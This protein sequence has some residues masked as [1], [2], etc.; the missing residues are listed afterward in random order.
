MDDFFFLADPRTAVA[1]VP[2]FREAIVAMM[3]SRPGGRAAIKCLG[4]GSAKDRKVMLRSVKDN[5]AEAACH[6][7]GHLVLVKALDVVDDT[8]LLRK[9]I[10]D[11]LQDNLADIATDKYV[12]T[13]ISLECGPCRACTVSAQHAYV[14]IHGCTLPLTA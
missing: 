11:T 9:S 2:P 1:A 6:D 14:M 8:V 10:L 7:Q 4:Y 3:S 5:A 13:G 12:D